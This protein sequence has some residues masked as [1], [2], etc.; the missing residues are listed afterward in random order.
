ML[1]RA[2]QEGL[3]IGRAVAAR[4]GVG[5]RDSDRYVSTTERC[6]GPWAVNLVAKTESRYQQFVSDVHWQCY[7]Q[8]SEQLA[9]LRR[10]D[11]QPIC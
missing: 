10:A 4:C 11:T 6:H 7:G 8:S 3:R 5:G 9:R 2:R 1:L